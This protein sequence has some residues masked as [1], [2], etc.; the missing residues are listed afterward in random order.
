MAAF[1]KEAEEKLLTAVRKVAEHVE[2]GLHPTDAVVKAASELRV[3][4]TYVPLLC[5][6]Y[7]HGRATAQ[8]EKCASGDLFCK[9]AEYPLASSDEAMAKLYPPKVDK[10]GDILS[11]TAVHDVYSRP[12]RKI[13]E[14]PVLEKAAAS[15]TEVVRPP[16]DVN[17]AAAR[18]FSQTDKIKK[19][20]EEAR[21]QASAVADKLLDALYD[22]AGFFKSAEY[23]RPSF[24]EIE[25]NAARLYGPATKSIM[26][27]AHGEARLSEKRASGP[28]HSVLPI[29]EKREPYASIRRAM[30]LGKEAL[31]KYAELRDI[32]AKVE[33]KPAEKAA[34]AK[35]ANF[36]TNI[37]AGGA[38]NIAADAFRQK[39][40]SE[41]VDSMKSDLNDPE[42]LDELRQIQTQAMLSNLL[43]YDDVISG[44]DPDEVREAYNEISQL[45]PRAASQPAIM[46]PL[47]R[48][49]LTSGALE[50]F[51]A[52][53]I[54]EVEK[55]LRTIDGS[56]PSSPALDNKP[57]VS[58]ALKTGK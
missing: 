28:V 57:Q 12:P 44:Y 4:P 23:A 47:L 50:T 3:P 46:R 40:P 22:V 15:K 42:H 6:S 8:R 37:L 39:Q 10:P 25:Y 29:S 2:D 54:P 24:A 43:N 21:R 31:A 1:S 55:T 30:D 32:E 9:L 35:E 36:F 48:K 7:N 20:A 14:S 27:F 26:D 18:Y 13:A 49:R 45:S 11:K 16:R 56:M 38:G 58:P 34:G 19:Q 33:P 41:I 53:E 17:A 52:G 5:Q 51:E